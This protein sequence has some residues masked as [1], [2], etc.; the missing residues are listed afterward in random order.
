MVPDRFITI[1][2]TG[3]GDPTV[4]LQFEVVDGVPQCRRL[5]IT[6]TEGGR[7][8]RPSDVHS[9]HVDHVL[10]LIYPKIGI[11]VEHGSGLE[12]SWSGTLGGAGVLPAVRSARKGRPRTMTPELLGEVAA[13]Y[14][15]H[16]TGGTP[17]VEVA[18]FF[19]VA[20]R[21]ARLYIKKARDSGL[22]GGSIPG[23]AGEIA[24]EGN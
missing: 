5:E 17:A 18:R 20:P 21:T 14:R 16:V 4:R 15:E 3:E 2:R 12:P 19:S 11:A 24:E 9:I 13:I 23:R 22:L 7:E 6:A 1:G 8:I 10:E